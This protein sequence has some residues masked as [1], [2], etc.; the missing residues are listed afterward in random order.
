[1][2]PTVRPLTSLA[3]TYVLIQ[4]I[5]YFS[6]QLIVSPH[7]RRFF[8]TFWHVISIPLLPYILGLFLW[9]NRPTSII[10]ALLV[11]EWHL[12]LVKSLWCGVL[13]L[14]VNSVTLVILRE[15]G[16]WRGELIHLLVW[17]DIS[18]VLVLVVAIERLVARRD[19]SINFAVA[20][21][22]SVAEINL[23]I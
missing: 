11:F 1:M 2:V 14:A 23:L 19:L 7:R 20:S 9:I 5:Q 4:H 12:F 13:M 21:I 6:F 15:S 17:H 10:V 3:R 18:V 8:L 22:E 16:R